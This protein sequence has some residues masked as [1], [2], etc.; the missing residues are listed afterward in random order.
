MPCWPL[1]AFFLLAQV[2]FVQHEALA[3]FSSARTRGTLGDIS[4]MYLSPDGLEVNIMNNDF[5]GGTDKYMTGAMSYGWLKT[6]EPDQ[7]GRILSHEILFDWRAL[8]PAESATVGG[9]RLIRRI[10]RYADWMSVHGSISYM[11]P[12][13]VGPIKVQAS[14][15]VGHIGNKG[16]KE[17][18]HAIH[19]GI[20]M[21]TS[22]LDYT[23]QPLGIN[24]GYDFF[25]GRFLPNDYLDVMVGAGLA[26]DKAM[27]ETYVQLNGQKRLSENAVT[28]LEFTVSRQLGSSIYDGLRPYRMELAASVRLYEYFQPGLKYITSFVHDDPQ[29][30]LYAELLRFNVPL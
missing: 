21:Q 14:L 23:D 2:F 30:Q 5:L 29:G 28:S 27:R 22:G 6:Y 3:G 10:G 13:S 8:T 17:L 11:M 16:M 26:L 1:L 9:K 15:A 12:T 18:H 4:N 7:E 25:A 19:S 20:G 24:E